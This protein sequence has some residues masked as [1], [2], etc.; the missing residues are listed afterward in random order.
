MQQSNDLPSEDEVKEARSKTKEKVHKDQKEH[1]EKVKAGQNDEMKRN[2][3]Q[4]TEPGDSLCS[5]A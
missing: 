4:I 5:R 2:L 3:E 1:L